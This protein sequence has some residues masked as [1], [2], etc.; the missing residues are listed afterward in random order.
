[1]RL[2]NLSQLYTTRDLID[3]FG[4]YNHNLRIGEGEFYDMKNLTSSY[5]P[6]LAPRKQRGTFLNGKKPLG[7]IEKDALCYV[8]VEGNRLHFWM[9]EK[10]YDLGL[11]PSD[12]TA[13]EE[14]TLT[15]MGAYVIITPD[16]KYINTGNIDEEG[17]IEDKGDIEEKYEYTPEGDSDKITFTLCKRDGEEYVV[18]KMDD[19]E[20]ENM[21]TD[22][23]GKEIPLSN[24]YLWLD[25]SQTPNSLKQ[26]SKVSG[27]WSSVATTYIR[28]NC[29][30]I[31]KKFNEYDGVK[32][33]GVT[34][35]SL[36]DLNNTMPIYAKGDDYIVVVGILDAATS[37]FQTD[38]ITV[39][40]QM[41]KMDFIVE[42]N[43][44]LW[45][46]RYGLNREGEVVNE[47]Y[48]S[49]LGDFKNW[50]RFLGVSTDSY[51]ASVG[52]DGLFTGAYSY[53][54]YPIFFKENCMHTVYGNFPSEYQIQDT[55]CRG[56]QKGSSKSL[57]MVNEVL[58]YKSRT[59]I[60]A[61]SG[62]LPAEVASVL[63]EKAY[64]EA[65]GCSHKG[66]YYISMRDISD[67]K[68]YLF[69]CDT[70]KGLWHKED[71][72][73]VKCFCPK[74]EEI[75]YIGNYDTVHTIFGS[76]EKDTTPIEW[77]AESGI[78]GCSSPDKKYIS[79]ITVRL[80]M[81]IGARV[82]F[83]I[84]YDSSGAWEN[85][86]SLVGHNLRTFTLPIR[87][88]RCDHFRLRIEGVGEAKIFSISKITEQ[89]SD[90]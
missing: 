54:G 35:E 68:K 88:K 79:R 12:V 30:G 18:N 33:S 48:A 11:I 26:F 56:V 37:L 20:P 16:R 49:C 22:A 80:S 19:V 58:Y 63:G 86:C 8:T 3:V 23:E 71:E 44:R 31:G 51:Y 15:S 67:N 55:A 81:E 27:L 61:Y 62:S 29:T 74:D 82:S 1:M 32:I 21:G 75:Y 59:G 53:L 6:V 24:G 4:G 14:R 47:I 70:Q 78:L 60:C 34:V 69:V 87:P 7:L 43:N 64:S 17:N 5:Y 50:N 84:Q 57:A 52:T 36:H 65:V 45:G 46:C 41:P 76:G 90:D 40:R 73:D 25:T 9:N 72:L 39:E 66:K 28:I 2:P 10:D 83:S 77:M 42:S 89:G 38:T 85:V 13:D